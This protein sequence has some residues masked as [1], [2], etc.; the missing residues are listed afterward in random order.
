MFVEKIEL[1]VDTQKSLNPG[2]AFHNVFS[3]NFMKILTEDC[4]SLFKAFPL[5]LGRSSYGVWSLLETDLMHLMVVCH[6]G[7]NYVLVN[8]PA[9]YETEI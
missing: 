1:E 9:F 5:G 2:M 7:L 8:K 6:D 3:M 4:S